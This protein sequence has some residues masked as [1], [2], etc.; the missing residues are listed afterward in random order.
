[1]P[2]PELNPPPAAMTPDV[3]AFRTRT[4][5]PDEDVDELWAERTGYLEALSAGAKADV[6]ARLKKRYVVP[7]DDV[8]VVG[9]PNPLPEI[10]VRWMTRIMTP[11]AYR[12]RGYDPQDSTLDS[13]EKDR[14][15]AYEEIKEAADA[16]DGLYDLPLR[17]DSA[18]AG[19]I[20]VPLGYSE[21]SPYD[22]TDK[23]IDAL[24]RTR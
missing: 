8:G 20:G 3:L 22:W 9:G 13:A 19:I 23:Q 17:T 16:K 14:E 15:R 4:F 7:F 18:S 5:M 1:M 24:G 10:V 12:A 11:E 2:S 6:E 21:P